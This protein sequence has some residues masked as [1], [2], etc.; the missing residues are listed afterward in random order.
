[1]PARR[2][3][4]TTAFAALAGSSLLHPLRSIGAGP[5]NSGAT[6]VPNEAGLTIREV[7]DL[8]QA[9]TPGAPFPDTVDTIKSGDRDQPVKGIVTTMFATD[10]VIDK[11]IRAGANFIIAHEPTFYN[12]PDET[13]WLEKDPVFQFKQQL[14][15]THNIVVWRFH[16]GIHAHRPDGIR[17]GVMDALGWIRY[18]SPDNPFLVTIPDAAFG[19]LV[20]RVKKSLGIDKMRVIGDS[21]QIIKKVV[22]APGSGGGRIQIGMI[23]QYQPDLIICGEINEWETSEYVR[24]ARYS[25]QK[26]SL[27]VLGHSVSE[28]PGMQWLVKWL[29]PKLPG[30]AITHIPSG[31]AFRT[32]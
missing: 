19:E 10:A 9:E 25:G 20:L 24:D 1:M 11:T 16:D 32:V 28:E 29:T 22:L 17:M 13:D 26:I 27:M 14:L 23:R 30:V 6:A 21:K 3:F 18:Y 7:I 5:A 8:I 31:E 15:K 4:L 12:H 2:E